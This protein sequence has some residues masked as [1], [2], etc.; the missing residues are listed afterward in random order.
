MPTETFF[1]LSKEKQERILK[2]AEQEFSRV[3]LHEASIARVI[4]EADISRGSFYQYFNDKEDLYYYYFQTLKTNGHRY[5]IQAIEDSGGDLFDGV[6]EYFSRLLPEV[7]EGENQ[8]FFR[9]LFMNMD[10]HGF[11]RVIPYLEKKVNKQEEDREKAI[12]KNQARLIQVVNQE[13]L[14]T[15][16]DEELILLF[17]MLMHILFSTIAEGYRQQQQTSTSCIETITQTFLIKLQWLKQGAR[18]ETKND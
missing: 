2:A 18:K 7:F 17:K 11:Q 1:N 12:K 4:K 13:N 9:H 3:G 16:S 14:Q 10:A 6:E 5:L 8:A 15:S